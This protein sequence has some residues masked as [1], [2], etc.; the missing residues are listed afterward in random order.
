MG[1]VTKAKQKIAQVLPRRDG[2]ANLLSGLGVQGRDASQSTFF[3][4]RVQLGFDTCQAL[5]RNEWACGRMVD[6]LAHDATRAGFM[7]QTKEANDQAQD[8]ERLWSQ[9]KVGNMLQNGL[10]WG[11]VYGG[12]VGVVLTDDQA[13]A[14]EQ[15]TALSTPLRPGT[16]SKILRVLVVERPWATP[17]TGDIDLNP[18]SQNYGLPNTYFVTPQLGGGSPVWIV[19]WTR[20]LRFDGVPVDSETA[21]ANLSYND[22]IYQRPYDIVRA[23]GAA[24]SATA[25]IVQRFTQAV[26]KQAGLLSNLVSDQED[27]VLS[28]LRAFNLGLG[29]TGLG[30]I[31]GANEDFQLMGQPVNGL[32]GLLLELRTELAGALAY[33]QARLYGA[34]A[35]ALASSETDEKQWASNVH[36]WQMLRVV[37]ALA[38]LTQI[39]LEARGAPA[40]D[41]WEIV[42]NPIQAPNAKLDAEVRKIAAETAQLNIQSGIIEPVEARVSQFGGATWTPNI[43]LDPAITAAMVASQNEADAQPEPEPT[44]EVE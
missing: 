34:Q 36:A 22:S 19:H 8:I 30:I 11:L 28:R 13:M 32:Q 20:I 29:V 21:L 43:T 40:I 39:A 14:Q 15:K 17:N 23:R 18:A 25:S 5:H 16:Y 31:D 6:D 33:P 44:P 38:R 27:G 42:P 37:P 1:A 2:W 4:G 41:G 12:A 35:G 24:V 9:L 26:I 10:R 7:L 3:A